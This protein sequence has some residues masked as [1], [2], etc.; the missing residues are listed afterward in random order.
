MNAVDIYV[1]G[2]LL[3]VF[4]DEEINLNRSVQNYKGLDKVFTDY[5]QSFTVPATP[6]N[7]RIFEHYYNVSIKNGYD[8]RLRVVGRIEVNSLPFRDGVVE[9]E[10]VQLRGGEPYAYTLGFYGFLANLT[11]LFGE[12]KL[13]DLDLSAYDHTYDGATILTGFNAN[14]LLSGDVFYPLMSASTNWFYNSNVGSSYDKDNLHYLTGTTRGAH[15]DDLKP[16]IKVASILSAIETKYSITFS[17]DWASDAQLAKL[18]LWMHRNEGK[19]YNSSTT[20]EWQLINMNRDTGSTLDEFDLSTDKWTV[21]ADDNYELSTTMANVSVDYELGFFVNGVLRSSRQEDAHAS[22]SKT[23]TFNLSGLY[24]DDVVEFKI[25]PQAVNSINYQCTNYEAED[26]GSSTLRFQVDQSPPATYTFEVKMS[27][28]APD[29]KISDFMA[30]LV[31]MHNLVITPI[32][33]TEFNLQSLDDWYGDGAE[34]DV[35]DFVQYDEMTV[36]RPELYKQISYKYQDTDQILGKAYRETN[37]VG[38][39]NL[40]NTFTFDG[41]DFAVELA[42]ECPLFERLTDPFGSRTNIICYKSITGEADEDGNYNPYLGGLVFIYGEWSLDISGNPIGFVDELSAATE[43]TETW[44]ANVSSSQTL[45]TAYSLCFGADIDPYHLQSVSKSLFD[46]Y[47]TTYITDLYNIGRRVVLV[48]AV[49]PLGK[50]L[51]LKMNDKVIFDNTKWLINNVDMNLT[52]GK[53]RF[54]LL[55]EV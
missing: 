22:T 48:D 52:T 30:S 10:N 20:I 35:Q 42:A 7:N 19:L 31:K 39:G 24:E 1:S 23:F 14:S 9:L 40:D 41:D 38:F 50:M 3:D 53:C 4:Q 55:N 15:Y 32:S 49:L 28:I 54:E 27:S 44:W 6:N 13:Y 16:A 21:V 8:A 34:V 43:V 51:T 45:G 37:A 46:T 5:T 36:N 33:T 47:W 29:V 11:D 12:D 2:E 17:G 25:R 18:F 26:Q